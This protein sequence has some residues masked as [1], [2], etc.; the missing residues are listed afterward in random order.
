VLGFW[1][2]GGWVLFCF[3]WVGDGGV[4]VVLSFSAWMCSFVF[5]LVWV[6]FSVLFCVGFIGFLREFIL[7]SGGCL[8]CCWLSL[9]LLCGLWVCFLLVFFGFDG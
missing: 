4:G 6:L 5:L 3:I 1:G 7:F 2:G 9:L 8:V